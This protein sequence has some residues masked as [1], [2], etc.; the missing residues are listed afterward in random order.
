MGEQV[1]GGPCVGV[2]LSRK[3]GFLFDIPPLRCDRTLKS[4]T[5][6][7]QWGILVPHLPQNFLP[8]SI[9]EPQPGQVGW[10][11]T[12]CG[13]TGGAPTGVPHFPQNAEPGTITFPHETQAKSPD[14]S[15]AAGLGY[16][17]GGWVL[18]SGVGSIIPST[19]VEISS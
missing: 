7:S 8:G 14:C 19:R 1:R 10:E 5:E 9:G 2:Y 17:I 15:S 6:L 13:E 4:D 12:G 18:I 11:G 16:T 3:K